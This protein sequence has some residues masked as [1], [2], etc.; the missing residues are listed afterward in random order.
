MRS[1]TFDG[2]PDK[3]CTLHNAPRA[4][5]HNKTKTFFKT[6]PFFR[7][8]SSYLL[9]VLSLKEPSRDSRRGC[10]HALMSMLPVRIFFEAPSRSDLTRSSARVGLIKVVGKE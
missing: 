8:F 9:D 6:F 5:L 3:V 7:P 1:D 4:A 10:G 2:L